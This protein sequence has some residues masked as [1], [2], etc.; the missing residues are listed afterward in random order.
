MTL[1]AVG[2]TASVVLAAEG[3]AGVVEADQ[4]TVRDGARGVGLKELTG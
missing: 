3:D 1:L 4:A 2:A